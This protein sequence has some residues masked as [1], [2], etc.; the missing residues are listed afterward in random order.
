MRRV[1]VNI[2]ADGKI[3]VEETKVTLRIL[4]DERPNTICYNRENGCIWYLGQKG[5]SIKC[6]DP[7]MVAIFMYY[8]HHECATQDLE[9]VLTLSLNYVKN[10][11]RAR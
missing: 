1:R 9:D 5:E 2:V 10:L 4:S 3:T 7:A 6:K 8:I 11:M